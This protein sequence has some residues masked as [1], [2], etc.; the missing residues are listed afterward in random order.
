[1]SRISK[2]P[3]IQRGLQSMFNFERVGSKTLSHT[4]SK[5]NNISSIRSFADE[6]TMNKVVKEMEGSKADDTKEV[7]NVYDTLGLKYED[8]MVDKW[9]YISHQVGT[10]LLLRHFDF[11]AYSGKNI[12]IF[13]CGSGTGLVTEDIIDNFHVFNRL[14]NTSVSFKGMDISPNMVEASINKNIYDECH[15]QS[16]DI[17]PYPYKDEEFDVIICM[18]V[19]PYC[20]NLQGVVNEW[21]RLLKPNGVIVASL[22]T[23]MLEKNKFEYF[24]EKEMKGNWQRLEL[25][26]PIVHIENHEAYQ[27]NK[28]A[29][30][31]VAKKCN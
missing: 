14:Y 18:G 10:K 25:T 27:E 19:L 21:E 9:G 22:R 5:L 17:T 28:M 26:K 23:D 15:V 8:V 30:Y 24:E 12:S 2:M 1:M 4:C 16:M 6:A 3:M 11:K 13:D 20:N 7:L 31:Y 29:F